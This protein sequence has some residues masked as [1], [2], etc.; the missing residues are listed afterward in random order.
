MKAVVR[1][2][3]SGKTDELIRLCARQGGYIVVRQ[4]DVDRVVRRAKELKLQIPFPVSFEEFSGGRFHGGSVS[5]LWIDNADMLLAQMTQH[6]G[7]ELGG[8]SATS[9]EPLFR[10]VA[11]KQPNHALSSYH[12][13]TR[14]LT[15]LSPRLFEMTGGE[16]K[17]N[18]KDP[19]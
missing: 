19:I 17:C 1:S 3:G 8:W 13:C 18:R 15:C 16:H 6:R 4:G 14:C 2:A 5:P 12:Q 10:R 7:A 9:E 11:V